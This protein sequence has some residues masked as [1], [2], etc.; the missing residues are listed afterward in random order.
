M[1]VLFLKRQ[2][3]PSINP[4]IGSVLNAVKVNRDCRMISNIMN[5]NGVNSSQF[6]CYVKDQC[7]CK[8]LQQKLLKRL[9]EHAYFNR[10]ISVKEVNDVLGASRKKFDV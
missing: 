1:D 8:E 7:L 10:M 9:C 2:Y 5:K 6:I 3:K 4:V